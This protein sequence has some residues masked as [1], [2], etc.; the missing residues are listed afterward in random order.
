MLK[1][2]LISLLVALVIAVITVATWKV[3]RDNNN[4]QIARIAE[5][6]AY[7]ARSQLVRNVDMM[8]DALRNVHRFWSTYGH[9]PRDQWSADAGIELVHFDGMEMIL[10]NDVERGIRYARTPENPVL[11]YRP[12]DDDWQA[13]Q[14]LL[15]RTGNAADEAVLG[16]YVDDNGR[17][18]Y[19]IY[20]ASIGPT[21]T[22]SLIAVVDA[23]KSF[24]HLL[25][26]QSPGYSI[27]VFWDDVLLYQR[28]TP[29]TDVPKNW[30]R[31]GM[32]RTSMENL[33][34][35]VHT[36]TAQF[37]ESFATPALPTVL[38]SGLAIAVLVGLLL[39]ENGRAQSRA[40]AAEVAEKKLADLNRNLEHQIADRTKELADR[41]ADL[42]TIT[43][44]VAHDLRNPLNTISVNT[45]LLEQQFRDAL[46]T[47][48]LVA[49]Q[50]T[51]SGIKRM[52]EILDRL[53]GLSVVSHATFRPEPLDL[54]ELVTD[55]FDELCASE[56]APRVEFAVDD[57]PNANADPTLV[58]TLVLNL[59][60]NALKYT[61]DRTTRRIEVT[62]DVRDG[63]AVYC[64]R[65]NG[66][67]FDGQS[68][69]RMFN[70][71]ERLDHDGDSEGV[72][73][74]LDI[75]TRVVGRH[76][77]RIWAEG[78]P[79]VG[80]AFYFTLEPGGRGGMNEAAMKAEASLT[81][82][83]PSGPLST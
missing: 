21:V 79:G 76:G 28:G 62:F 19:L 29:A 69:K 66:I 37:A 75:A 78:K 72:G 25:L 42:E 30:Y 49:L 51:S 48:G 64:V 9:L 53:L 43:D 60:S 2:L 33:W 67:G 20:I 14:Y 82:A 8:L 18:S 39:F 80:A 70:A 32:I 3:L 50:R 1:R 59:L 44:S 34:K 31:E 22:G 10:W 15:A 16:P 73:L 6:E 40:L 17:V 61:R 65:D 7:A 36:P 77:G 74:G 13:L 41:S 54:R 58:R 12:T 24:A 71:F 68:A 11:D 55:I 45:Q 35:V 4:A 46:G 63:I 81:A 83:V 47:D 26:D 57:L 5:S 52:T 38:F 56:P 27:S 23:Q